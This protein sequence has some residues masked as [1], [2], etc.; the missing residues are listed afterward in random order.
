MKRFVLAWM[1]AGVCAHAENVFPL[2]GGAA[3]IEFVSPSSFRFARRGTG[4]SRP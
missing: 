3:E 2:A 1:A 4:R